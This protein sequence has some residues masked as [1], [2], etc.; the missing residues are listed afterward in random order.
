MPLRGTSCPQL[1]G[2][3]SASD[4]VF[5][6]RHPWGCWH[7][8]THHPSCNPQPTTGTCKCK[9]WPVTPARGCSLPIR[10]TEA[11][12]LYHQPHCHLMSLG[13]PVFHPMRVT[14]ECTLV[15]FLTSVCPRS[16]HCFDSN[17]GVSVHS[18]VRKYDASLIKLNEA[19]AGFC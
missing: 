5:W 3:L 2:S 9:A 13:I 16:W 6:R 12:L 10:G 17:S 7:T 15:N 14:Q 11:L 18:V 4:L 8:W 19:R 1:L